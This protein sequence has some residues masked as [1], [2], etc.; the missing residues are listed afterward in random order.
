[1]AIVLFALTTD[2]FTTDDIGDSFEKMNA[3]ARYADQRLEAAANSRAL[4]T[5]PAVLADQ[6]DLRF[7]LVMTGVSQVF[8]V[9]LVIM[10]ARQGFSGFVRQ[11]GMD[12]IK[13]G[14]IWLIAGCV[15]LA[16]AGTFLYSIAAAATGISWLEPTSTVPAAVIRDD[17]TFAIT[18]IVTLI[19]APLSEEM[20][21]RGL[22]FSGLSRWGT[23]I[24]AVISGFMFSL[25]HFD[26]GSFIPFVGIALLIGWIYW[27]RGSLWDS[28]AF[29]FLF[30]AT[31][32]SI[33]A[34]TR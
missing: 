16:Y 11:T 20:F 1:V 32:F 29:H 13:P 5:P 30:N 2:E 25:V 3:V 23:I 10:V 34:A 15:I 9:A 33:M 8:L 4:P 21:F 19:G 12:Q 18:G 7:A 27:R 17:T 22:V 24:A 31:S 6:R 14:R 28:I 26:P